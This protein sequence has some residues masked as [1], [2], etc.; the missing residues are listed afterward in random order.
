MTLFLL[1]IWCVGREFI[2]VVDSIHHLSL[3]IQWWF[4]GPQRLCFLWWFMHQPW[5]SVFYSF[6]CL[7]WFYFAIDLMHRSW[8]HWR[9]RLHTAAVTQYSLTIS[10]STATLFSLT[11]L[12]IRSDIAFFTFPCVNHYS[13]F[14]INLMRRSLVYWCCRFHTSAIT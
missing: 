7:P 14:A 2:D 3:S 6:M 1:S 13:S 5:H 11:I 8:I 10:T 4:R 12:W 9:C